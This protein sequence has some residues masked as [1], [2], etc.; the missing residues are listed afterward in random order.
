MK[1]VLA[2][3]LLVL[4]ATAVTCSAADLREETIDYENGSLHITNPEVMDGVLT[5]PYMYED[6]ECER[7]LVSELAAT[8]L[9][10]DRL[11]IEDGI[12]RVTIV[13]IEPEIIEIPESVEEIEGK[14]RKSYI[15]ADGN[16]SYC[17]IDGVLFSKDKKTLISY[18]AERDTKR[19]VVPEGTETIGRSSFWECEALEEVVLGQTVKSVEYDAFRYCKALSHITLP[20]GLEYIDVSA[21][22]DT[23]WYKEAEKEWEKTGKSVV[24]GDGI[25][26]YAR[27]GGNFE[28]DD[29]VKTIAGGLFANHLKLT[30]AFD[31]VTIGGSVKRIGD[32]AFT[33]CDVTGEIIIE[34]GVEEIG[35]EAFAGINKNL[36]WIPKV[37]LPDSVKKIGTNAFSKARIEEIYFP[38]GLQNKALTDCIA[39]CFVAKDSEFCKE[40]SRYGYLTFDKE[41]GNAILP[42]FDGT[43]QGAYAVILVHSNGEEGITMENTETMTFENSLKPFMFGGNLY[44]P[45]RHFCETFDIPLYWAAEAGVAEVG[46]RSDNIEAYESKAWFGDE[47]IV[48]YNGKVMQKRNSA[49][50]IE[51]SIYVPIAGLAESGLI[52]GYF[53]YEI[54]PFIYIE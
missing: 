30:V 45:L 32:R 42:E 29:N 7:V 47:S 27:N 28:T 8:S 36:E 18:G 52:K 20:E 11:V 53:N 19:Y 2:A 43:T 1:K 46:L 23:L 26:F 44:V 25:L 34:D 15:V 48:R 40:M 21:V 31:S 16:G 13:G 22:S 49:V 14:A 37:I 4:M 51:G 33:G 35:F 41:T 6:K 38:D 9:T 54:T 5:L 17:D 50:N 3:L 10:L 12:K 24:I 39:K